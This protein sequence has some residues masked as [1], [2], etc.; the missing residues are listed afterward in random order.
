MQISLRERYLDILLLKAI[1]DILKD[2]TSTD[3]DEMYCKVK[4]KKFKRQD[5]AE[6][7]EDFGRR[8]MQVRD[9]A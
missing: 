5:R 3:Q 2:F 1:V 4:S 8:A 9:S 7:Q 6:I